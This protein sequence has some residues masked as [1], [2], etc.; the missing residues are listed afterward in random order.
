[1]QRRNGRGRGVLYRE[2]YGEGSHGEEGRGREQR[3]GSQGEKA[4]EGEREIE[5]ERERLGTSL[6]PWQKAHAQ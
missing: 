2:S 5:R 3:M 1:M 6:Q 4:R